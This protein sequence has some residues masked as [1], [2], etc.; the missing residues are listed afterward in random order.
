VD[1]DGQLEGQVDV[2][3]DD[4]RPQSVGGGTEEC[5]PTVCG[6]DMGNPDYPDVAVFALTQ[7][8]LATREEV[9]GEGHGVADLVSVPAAQP[10]SSAGRRGEASTFR[11]PPGEVQFACLKA[12]VRAR[13]RGQAVTAYH[14]PHTTAS[15][16]SPTEMTEAPD[17]ISSKSSTQT[18]SLARA[19][20]SWAAG[21]WLCVCY[22][23]GGEVSGR[24][25]G[26]FR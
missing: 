3:L 11:Y 23:G 7:T 25:E 15:L 5:G 24:E 21:T 19:L 4:L 20:T 6:K 9:R 12:L 18:W 14:S 22:G 8:H 17:L 16:P 1:A 13:G 10:C 2:D 26:Q